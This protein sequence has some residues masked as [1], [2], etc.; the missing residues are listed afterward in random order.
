MKTRMKMILS[1]LAG[2][3]ITAATIIVITTLT[4]SAKA[5]INDPRDNASV[6]TDKTSMQDFVAVLQTVRT[7]IRDQ[8]TLEFYDKL[9]AEYDLDNDIN[10]TGLPDIKKIQYTALI[11]PL[12][13]AG[14]QIHDPE[15][16]NFYYRFLLQN[17]LLDPMPEN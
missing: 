10:E 14:K 4:P 6:N 2:V 7:E 17:G 16:K 3:V 11:L 1:F 5:Q 15:I 13:E 8:D 9:I 12:Q